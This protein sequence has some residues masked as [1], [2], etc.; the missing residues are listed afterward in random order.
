MIPQIC[1]RQENLF[2]FHHNSHKVSFS[3]TITKTNT[4]YL[5]CCASQTIS[6]VFL[7][8]IMCKNPK[9]TF[10]TVWVVKNITNHSIA[11]R[12][13]TFTSQPWFG[14]TNVVLVSNTCCFLKNISFHPSSSLKFVQKLFISFFSFLSP[15]LL[16]SFRCFF[17]PQSLFCL[18]DPLSNSTGTPTWLSSQHNCHPCF[19]VN[20]IPK[21]NLFR[22]FL[23]SPFIFPNTFV[24]TVLSFLFQTKQSPLILFQHNVFLCCGSGAQIFFVFPSQRVQSHTI[25]PRLSVT[26]LW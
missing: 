5:L 9:Q 1:S 18:H 11:K 8:E 10:Q 17:S 23:D 20:I 14:Q 12:L 19:L 15:P 24:Q 7:L 3:T 2:G 21:N 4:T 26:F 16:F 22:S 13:Q 6:V 25:C